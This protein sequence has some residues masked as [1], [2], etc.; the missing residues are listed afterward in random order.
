MQRSN[1]PLPAHDV[2]SN[3][4]GMPGGG[5][6]LKFRIDR[7]ITNDSTVWKYSC[8]IF[9]AC[10]A[11]KKSC[12]KTLTGMILEIHIFEMVNDFIT[13]VATSSVVRT[14]GAK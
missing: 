6:M 13:N 2:Q 9:L 12:R 14:V 7:R 3:A 8:M 1:S 10:K 4:R 11:S 5:G